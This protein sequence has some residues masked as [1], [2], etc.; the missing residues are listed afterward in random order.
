MTESVDILIKADD[1]ASQGFKDAATNI[2]KSAKRVEQILGS[3]EDP[4][5]KYN[6]QLRELAHLQAE[7]AITAEQ[8]AIAEAKLKQ[9]VEANA[10]TMK[11][12]GGQAKKT[13][14]FVRT[15]ASLTGNS[16]I[17]GLAGQIGDIA[18]KA[19]KF[20]EVSKAG[21]AGAMAFKL[22]LVG[23]VAT[24][25]A[26][27]GKAIGDVVFQTAKWERAMQS[28]KDEAKLLDD[29]LKRTQANM[30]SMRKEDIELIR[31]PDQKRAAHKQLLDE[32]NR[33]IQALSGN[34]TK[35]KRE[36]EEWADAWQ[37]TG[38]RKALAAMAEEQLATDQE[39]LASLKAQRDEIVKIT[40]V[41]ADENAAI[42]A[43][44]EAKDKSESYLDTL[45]QEVQYLQA[46]REE[47]IKID[48]LRNTTQ[49]DRG[50]AEQLLRARDAI[51]AQKE[52]MEEKIRTQQ[53]A[54]EEAIKAAER[55]EQEAE[56]EL[57]R[58]EDIVAAEQERL[59]LQR[60]ELEQGKEAAKAREL[61]N[62]GVDASTAKALAAEEAAIE[63]LKQK[64]AESEK[65]AEE[66][67]VAEVANLQASQSRLL[68][69]GQR[70][71]PAEETNKI[72]QQ[73]LKHAEQ[74][75]KFN[76][77]QLQAQQQIAANT[78]NTLTVRPTS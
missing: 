3:L 67:K 38:E 72:L 52:A 73:S 26:G 70:S 51:I 60:I 65:P 1:K 19:G 21:G 64:K 75:A 62:R 14:D 8:F 57:Q 43:A 63:L 30:F 34:V 20:S 12:M 42:R 29:Q 44:N 35:G 25:G 69:R 33:D 71:N 6:K 37:V 50:E 40:S 78:A 18:D 13:G 49:E 27:I 68:T 39:R 31:D 2:D 41:R 9:K 54:Q 58:V 56:K 11:D 23:L 32:L 5:E 66:K 47:Q 22:G 4:A 15:L 10:A 17:A 24:I 36:V 16:E 46:T 7:G 45:R 53:R 61:E 55:A 77:Q 59:A 76:E 28:A 48:A 74:L